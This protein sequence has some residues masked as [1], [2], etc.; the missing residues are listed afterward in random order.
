MSLTI[1]HQDTVS[2]NIFGEDINQLLRKIFD[3]GQVA[4][5]LLVVVQYVFDQLTGLIVL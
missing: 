4:L 2:L 3:A 5:I 1:L